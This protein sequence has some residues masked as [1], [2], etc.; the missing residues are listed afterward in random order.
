ML[1]IIFDA[2]TKTPAAAVADTTNLWPV[3]IVLG[4]VAVLIFGILLQRILASM[5]RPDLHGLSREK[6]KATWEQIEKSSGMGIM[7][8]KLAVIE[9]DKLLDGVLKSMLI[10]G[11]TLGER[12]KAAQYS[13][14]NIKNVWPAHKLRNQLVHDATFEITASQARRALADFKAA[15]HTLR[16]L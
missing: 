13:H 9:A 14:P 11:E 2:G 10:P 1:Q 8:A 3:W 15:L 5:R 7:G 16:A 4:L 6:I 12:L